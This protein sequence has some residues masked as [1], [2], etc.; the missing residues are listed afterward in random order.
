MK[1]FKVIL[2][3][4]NEAFRTALKRF[5]IYEYN[6]DVTGEASCASE[7]RSLPNVFQADLI[8]MDVMMPGENGISITK[9]FLWKYP[10]SRIIA[11]TMHSDK[12]YLLTLIEAGFKGCIFKNE[13]FDKLDSAITTVMANKLFF[14]EVIQIDNDNG[15]IIK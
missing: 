11:I 6:A 2:V 1:S 5:L 7:F 15:N 14:P 13:L 9:E 8:F 4:D 10:G 12:V 3:D